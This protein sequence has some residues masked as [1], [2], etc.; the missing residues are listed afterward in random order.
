MVAQVD[1]ADTTRDDVVG[2]ITGTKTLTGAPVVDTS[3]IATGGA[4]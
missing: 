1:A 3:V 4:Q 2:Y